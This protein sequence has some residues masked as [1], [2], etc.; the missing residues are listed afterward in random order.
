MEARIE[1]GTEDWTDSWV[2]GWIK[3]NPQ[4]VPPLS[5]AAFAGAAILSWHTYVTGFA[6]TMELNGQGIIGRLTESH[7]VGQDL[8]AW[9]G[10]PIAGGVLLA[11]G[12]FLGAVVFSTTSWKINAR[13][14]FFA[15]LL[16]TAVHVGESITLRH[17]DNE[18]GAGPCSL[19]PEFSLLIQCVAFLI[20]SLL[21]VAAVVCL[22]GASIALWRLCAGLR[23]HRSR[24]ASE[25]G[26]PND[27]AAPVAKTKI[28]CDP[29]NPDHAH[30][31]V[32]A[33]FPETRENG[34]IG[35]C[36]SGGGMR[37]ATFS[38]GALNALQE[39]REL[40]KSSYVS[41]VS[42]GAYMAGAMLLAIRQSSAAASGTGDKEKQE[43]VN[44][45][46]AFS[47]GS[48]EFDYLRRNANYLAR[49]PKEWLIMLF[50][51]V[52][53]ALFSAAFLAALAFISGR[54]IG[55]FYFVAQRRAVL[56]SPWHPVW[57]F[58]VP[59]V[60]LALLAGTL[61]ITAAHLRG[62][63]PSDK[64]RKEKCG[65]TMARVAECLVWATLVLAVTGAVIPVV[66]WFSG[67]L[68]HPPWAAKANPQPTT[69]AQGGIL[70]AV[71][72]I[73]GFLGIWSSRLT[74]VRSALK[75]VDQL[76]KPAARLGDFGKRLLQWLAVYGGLALVACMYILL[77]GITV[78]ATADVRPLSTITLRR[79]TPVLQTHIANLWITI[80]LT[81]ALALLCRLLDETSL[82][83]HPFYRESLSRAFAVVRVRCLDRPNAE[84]PHFTAKGYVPT[85]AAWTKLENTGR[86]EKPRV[87]FC[88]SAHSSDRSDIHPGRR[89]YP[90][91]FSDDCVGGPDN[92][93]MNVED[94]REVL[95]DHGL[96]RYSRDLTV[97]TAMAVSG[98]AFSSAMGRY[99]RPANV[100]LALANARLGTW[101][102][103]PSYIGGR[104]EWHEPLVPKR[105]TLS[106][107]L[108]EIFGVYPGGR[109][110]IFVTD[111]G[112]YENL[113]LIELFR[114]RC[115]E[116][117]CFDAST[118]KRTFAAS[119]ADAVALA[120]E[121]LGVTVHLT[122]PD[123][124]MPHGLTGQTIDSNLLN[125]R[126][127]DSPVIMGRYRYPDD[128]AEGKLVIGRATL[129]GDTPWEVQRYAAEHQ[130]FPYDATGDQ[131]FD[132]DRFN[133]Y[134]TLGRHV[135]RLSYQAMQHL[136]YPH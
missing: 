24:R 115:M 49:T 35:I 107:L 54:W 33:R 13:A 43:P 40:S 77:F 108:R 58:L 27:W 128:G 32:N 66:V 70:G 114:H 92:C 94:L 76:V 55:H 57:G 67:Q 50:A 124:A 69:A 118:D 26:L 72:L 59:G 102:V 29:E 105:R 11:L 127:A 132:T 9:W 20:Y 47:P 65:K 83:L 5:L 98:A 12:G 111:G 52:R 100:L 135:G 38:L 101:V 6:L 79:G 122:S 90:F 1:D 99:S 95:E 36:L 10:A 74:E 17:L 82:G 81:L 34:G 30:W 126:I 31:S 3:K 84:K 39:Q 97:Q 73:I 80:A 78:R 25:G 2:E 75:Q 23:R 119:I 61:W 103:N 56:N 44:W 28:T 4:W 19:A 68:V 48:P 117:Y 88:A 51:A 16:L 129:D 14:A 91:T 136:R 71:G 85:A 41:A 113:G 86:T 112:H 63:E 134:T 116:I 87:I 46:N 62:E 15:T 22:S 104:R 89:V 125:A 7:S 109:P 130:L 42:G 96:T 110:L 120:Y 131:F 60:F 123:L 18:C 106:Y 21:P 121:E 93:W 64:G 45:D 37:S 8:W 53:G 133:A